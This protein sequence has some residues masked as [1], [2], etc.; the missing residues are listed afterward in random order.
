M[1]DYTS[2][3][4]ALLTGHLGLPASGGTGTG[5]TDVSGKFSTQNRTPGDTS[6]DI[7]DLIS[8]AVAGGYT[9]FSDDSIRSNFKYLS[10][11]IGEEKARKLFNQAFIYNQRP[12][13]KQKTPQ[14]KIQ[15]FYDIGSNDPE[16]NKTLES[17]KN[18]GAGV[19]ARFDQSTYE[20]NKEITGKMK[21]TPLANSDQSS[22]LLTTINKKTT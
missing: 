18:Q 17:I 6:L 10:G 20:G 22:Q 14:Q 8:H 16:V 7:S 21:A 1:P 13:A 15:S 9:S 19:Q 4:T 3:L 12:D 11:V 5:M 2:N